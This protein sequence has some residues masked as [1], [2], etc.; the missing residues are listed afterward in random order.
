MKVGWLAD[1]GNTDGTGIGGAELTALEFRRRPPTASRSARSAPTRSTRSATATSSPSSTAPT[2]RPK[3]SH[4]LK[5]KR[6][7]RYWSDIAPF[8][9]PD[10]TRWLVANAANVFCSPLH[11]ERFPWRNGSRAEYHLI[12]P[13]VALDRFRDAAQRSQG[14]AGA[15]SISAWRGW[16]KIPHLSAR[17]GENNGVELDFYGGGP[18]APEGSQQILYADMPDLLARYET[19]VYLPAQLEP[20]CRMVAEADAAGCQVVT[21]RLVG[22][23]YWLE[24]DRGA[25]ET[26]TQDFW[27]LVVTA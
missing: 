17:W 16:G 1:P 10:L 23:L 14:R 8:G 7:V 21:N 19:F 15:C 2:T 13:P 6:V 4:A 11:H 20:F 3:P 22:A 18:C 26:A 25:L 24:N 12:P 27:K 5:G 9:D